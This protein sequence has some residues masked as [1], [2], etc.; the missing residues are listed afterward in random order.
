MPTASSSVP[1]PDNLEFSWAGWASQSWDTCPASPAGASDT[2]YTPETCTSLAVI[3]GGVEFFAIKMLINEGWQ[4]TLW[5]TDA[6]S[7][8]PLATF[9]YTNATSFE[10]VTVAEGWRGFTYTPLW[11]ADY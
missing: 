5:S 9:D 4:V 7:G 3:Q 2:S 11:N 8:D 1:V 6:C 10:C